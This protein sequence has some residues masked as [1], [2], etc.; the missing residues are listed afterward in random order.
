MFSCCTPLTVLRPTQQPIT[1]DYFHLGG[2]NRPGCE[3]TIH[4]HLLPRFRMRGAMLLLP[5]TLLDTLY[6]R[7]SVVSVS[8]YLCSAATSVD[9]R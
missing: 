6:R 7:N 8:A 4:L 3:A 5:P 2:K 9:V 1:E